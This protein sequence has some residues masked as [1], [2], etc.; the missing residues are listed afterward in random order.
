MGITLTASQ[1][2]EVDEVYN[3][4]YG[5]ILNGYEVVAGLAKELGSDHPVVAKLEKKL[6]SDALGL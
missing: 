6:E 1:R 5:T 3:G 4:H 2:R